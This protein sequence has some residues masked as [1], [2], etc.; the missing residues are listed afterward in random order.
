MIEQRFKM[1][2]PPESTVNDLAVFVPDGRG[3]VDVFV[4]IPLRSVSYLAEEG[5]VYRPI[6]KAVKSQVMFKLRRLVD[7]AVR[8]WGDA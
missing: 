8:T 5:D 3:W 1:D 7:P 6:G 4:S 2:Y